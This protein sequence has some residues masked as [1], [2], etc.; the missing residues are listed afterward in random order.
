MV[1]RPHSPLIF[2]EAPDIRSLD[3]SESNI[4]PKIQGNE[5]ETEDQTRI[6]EIKNKLKQGHQCQG[7]TMQR[8]IDQ[9]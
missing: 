3:E 8:G 9:V 2:L 1:R 5:S 6:K 7:K 4:S